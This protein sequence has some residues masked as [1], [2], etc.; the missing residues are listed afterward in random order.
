MKKLISFMLAM[1]MLLS[2]A[3]C[4]H[5]EDTK[6][7][8]DAVIG[9]LLDTAE[10]VIDRN[11]S[12]IV[13]SRKRYCVGKDA[14]DYRREIMDEE[15]FDDEWLMIVED[16]D[17]T[18]FYADD[19][20]EP[21]E[22]DGRM[23]SK[24]K[25]MTLDE[26]YDA[27][28][29]EQ[30]ETE[31]PTE[32]VTTAPVTTA[33]TTTTAPATTTAAIQVA[34]G[35]E[36][37]GDLKLLSG[38]STPLTIVSANNEIETIVN[39][40]IDVTGIDPDDVYYYSL[41]VFGSEAPERID[42]MFISGDDIDVYFVQPDW[43][44][45]FIDNPNTAAPMSALGFNEAHF[46]NAYPY[47]I[48][49]GKSTDGRFMS[50]APVASPGGFAY[51]TLLAEEY[52]GVLSPEEMQYMVC[53]WDKFRQ[54]AKSI[55]SIT[56]GKVA[57]ADSLGGLLFAYDQGRTSPWVID[58]KLV[59]DDFCREMADTAKNLW[60]IGGVSHNTQ[61]AIEWEKSG[62]KYE[63]MGYFTAPWSVGGFLMNA[64]G[65]TDGDAYGSWAIC[66]GPQP[67]YWGGYSIVVNPATDNGDLAQSLIYYSCID[68]DSM[69]YNV[70]FMSENY[71]INN[72][73]VM[74][75]AMDN[76]LITVPGDVSGNLG[77][78]DYFREFHKNALAID[79]TGLVTPYD[80]AARD[81]FFYAV[82]DVYCKD[83]GSYDDVVKMTEE[84]F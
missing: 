30:L 5:V 19:F 37:L 16:G 21:A 48:E 42:Q 70:S 82:A 15:D 12:G 35:A 1:S 51:N 33:V 34:P 47:T 77:G 9:D 75:Y 24:Y 58:N 79:N 54:S 22:C 74:E 55:Y 62:E 10:D 14:A 57:L 69:L 76:G 80:A 49:L 3:A 25:G 73:S 56:D 7:N 53:D 29:E 63:T 28:I 68:E 64:A 41:D 50:P 38:G 13:S 39:N 45:H 59:L 4:G 60:D 40:W 20:D 26:I 11:F 44:H 65:G 8:D 83:G 67:Y 71:F 52:L 18:F 78:Q 46:S 27:Y 72:T 66:Q 61:W 6:K 43:A 84:N 2:A 23:P 31:P 32:E 81:A 17:I 36:P